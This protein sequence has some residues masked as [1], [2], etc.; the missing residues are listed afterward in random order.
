MIINISYDASVASCPQQT[1]FKACV[2]AVAD[3]YESAFTDPTTV[4]IHVG[5]GEVDGQALPANS[6]AASI[7]NY[8]PQQYTYAQIRSA[9]SADA[10]TAAD[11]TAVASLGVTDPTSGGMF[12]MT[13][14]EAK[15]LGL[16]N[17]TTNV[18]GWTGIDT[19]SAWVFNTTS[20]A[21]GN[22]PPNGVDAFSFLAHEFAEILG[23]QMDF[24]Y[25]SGDNI[26][27][28]GWYPYD[29]FDYA[30]KGVRA[31]TNSAAADRYFSIDGGVTNTGQ[32]WFNNNGNSGDLFDY[33][34]NGT[35]GSY[36]P[37]GA[38]DSYDYAGSVGV[39]SAADLTLMNVLG[40]DPTFGRAWLTQVSADFA[41]AADW[42]G[43][44]VPGAANIAVLNATGS[45][46][47]T[48]TSS[49]TRTVSSLQTT[50]MA[51]LS[52][53]GG[54]FSDTYGTGTG[55]NGGTISVASSATF[56]A[57]GVVNNAKTI[58]VLA[59]GT[60]Q[61]AAGGLILT[62]AGTLSLAGTITGAG[63]SAT[64][65]NQSHI[66][67]SG[68]LGAGSMLLRN[69][70]AGVIESLGASQLVIND[71]AYV[72][73]NAGLI[74]SAGS[75]GLKI[76]GALT[77]GGRLFAQTGALT[78]TGSITGAGTGLI[79]PSGQLIL[80]GAFT[81][82]VTFQSGSTGSLTLGQSQGYTGQITGFSTSGANRLILSDISYIAGTTSASYSGT[83]ASGTLTVTDGT[84]TAKIKLA[85]NFLS[86][87]FK[88]SAASGGGVQVVDPTVA[89]ATTHAF[90]SA[91]AAFAA[92][93]GAHEA[94]ARSG[95]WLA[96]RSL[97]AAPHGAIA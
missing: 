85:G 94:G 91:M 7:S 86:S 90:V 65:I 28:D 29:L 80:Q 2:A 10:K 25:G 50:A 84:H 83:S 89:G 27:G 17:S 51:T 3:F 55:G 62:G 35:A 5:W 33:I 56:A 96:P 52:I 72:M 74:E 93:G 61:V 58:S 76:M 48:V 92:P 43:G 24:G 22:V 87:T 54:V 78:V 37:S 66:T 34:P 95:D 53:T 60:L 23:R 44:V 82:N 11:K 36:L 13:T 46:A 6:G 20:S 42:G 73:S 26:G 45:T 9:F 14:A 71:G 16:Y 30:S 47:Y 38:P 70:G 19:A 59:G 21:G 77:N 97:M 12:S 4:N 88:L 67:G 81:G 39:V 64:L 57:G 63:A 1:A 69:M 41:T 31:L 32:H 15:S 8:T 79:G 40:Y 18:D 68:Q 49:T 75:G